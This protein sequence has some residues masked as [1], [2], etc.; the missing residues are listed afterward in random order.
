MPHDI[1]N[2]SFQRVLRGY[3]P[4]EVD[5]YI[6]YLQD[7]YRKLERRTADSE[8]KLALAL[9]KLDESI[10]NGAVDT[11]GPAAREAASKLLK[12]AEAEAARKVEE[13]NARA[14]AEAAVLLEEAGAKAE[15]VLA[16]AMQ[17]AEAI[18]AEAEAEA[19][20]HRDDVKKAQETAQ[21]IFAEVGAFRDRLY[22]LYNE[23]LDALEGVTDAAQDFMDGVNEQAGTVTDAEAME[24]A[25]E[26]PA[27][28]EE[29]EAPA[30]TEE[31]PAEEE[32]ADEEVSAE[33]SV[34]EEASDAEADETAEVPEEEFAEETE[35]WDGTEAEEEP[36]ADEVASNLAFMDRLFASLQSELDAEPAGEDLYIDIPEEEESDFEDYPE[37]NFDEGVS[38]EESEEE[39]PSIMI[40]WKNRSAVSSD[41]TAE[42]EMPVPDESM[43]FRSADIFE[44]GEEE[45]GD[46]EEEPEAEN[47]D[48]YRPGDI[49]ADE[50]TSE[51]EP[52]EDEDEE[53]DEYHDMDEIFNADKSARDM[54]LT[55]EFNII[56]D[57][58][59]S[60]QN[61][62]E[63]SRQPIVAP[64]N[65]KN[66][67]KHKKN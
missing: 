26:S 59:K 31:I 61:V 6:A 44:D 46:F 30:E 64:E 58:S 19:E 40:D 14:E 2:K 22:A 52:E 1:R 47:Y 48:D 41:E 39:F 21:T 45:T 67:K 5:E 16:D 36:A 56:F 49:S 17:R 11:V 12:E 34:A 62:K 28:A 29:T 13:A 35:V 18:L 9:K 55:D 51:G 4:D 10:R 54:S 27:E 8:R 7:E 32:N 23:H 50:E 38:G 20:A 15:A 43:D 65:P 24:E 37:E 53:I 60:S 25:E 42:E 3:A 66:A 63:I 57:D 33:E